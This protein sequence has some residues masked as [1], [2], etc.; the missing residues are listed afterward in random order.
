MS[1]IAQGPRLLS[2]PSNYG[3]DSPGRFEAPTSNR[4]AQ[5]NPFRWGRSTQ[6]Q[7]Y[8]KRIYQKINF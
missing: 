6:R 1:E 7:K 5:K 2:A 8:M 3:K 4:I